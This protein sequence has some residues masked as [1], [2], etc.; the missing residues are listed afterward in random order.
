[1]L[2]NGDGISRVDEMMVRGRR[3]QNVDEPAEAKE[4]EPVELI[5]GKKQTTHFL[6]DPVKHIG[7]QFEPSQ[8]NISNGIGP[9]TAASTS[10]HRIPH[11]DWI[12]Y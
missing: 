1:M 5:A 8:S 11:E 3:T 6:L 12:Q 9:L 7:T 4:G 10:R 2:R